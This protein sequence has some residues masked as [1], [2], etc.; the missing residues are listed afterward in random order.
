M[1]T[2]QPID[3]SDIDRLIQEKRNNAM[4]QL[5]M[6]IV[7]QVEMRINAGQITTN[8]KSDGTVTQHVSFNVGNMPSF[9]KVFPFGKG[10]QVCNTASPAFKKQTEEAV[11]RLKQLCIQKKIEINTTY[12]ANQMMAL[13]HIPK[14]GIR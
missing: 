3:T 8:Q 14:G 6:E 11:S 9:R 13:Y 7:N 10:I 12:A 4:Q 5:F 1:Y 2:G